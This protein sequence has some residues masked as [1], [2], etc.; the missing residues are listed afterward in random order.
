MDISGCEFLEFN[1]HKVASFGSFEIGEDG[2]GTVLPIDN[3]IAIAINIGELLGVIVQ[4][5][6]HLGPPIFEFWFGTIVHTRV[7]EDFYFGGRAGW[8]GQCPSI[9]AKSLCPL[10]INQAYNFLCSLVAFLCLFLGF[11]SWA[12]AWSSAYVIVSLCCS[13]S[14]MWVF[15]AW[16]SFATSS[17]DGCGMVGLGVEGPAGLSKSP[18]IVIA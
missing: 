17:N 6:L 2:I 1:L 3:F 4:P 7:H 11:V 14:C 5:W 13:N 8:S 16:I 12:L 15:W 9:S 10:L 18:D